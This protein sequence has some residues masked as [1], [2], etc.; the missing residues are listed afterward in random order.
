MREPSAVR[1]LA[2]AI[3]SVPVGLQLSVLYTLL[4]AATLALLGSV[5]YARVDDFLVRDQVDRLQ[6][7]AQPLLT[8]TDF[9][10]R[11]ERGRGPRNEGP[12]PGPLG[13]TPSSRAEFA[14]LSLVRGLS[15]PD[16]TVAL[17]DAEGEVITSTLSVGGVDP[18]PLPA[19]PAGWMMAASSAS[20]PGEGAHWMVDLE[21]RR[22]LVLVQ[23]VTLPEFGGLSGERFYLEQ[24]A[25][26]AAADSLLDQ[27]RLYVLVG[28]L[29]GTLIGVLAGLG[30][31]R[32]V[33]RPL[34]R[35]VSTAE[36]ISGGDLGRR[37]RLPLGRNE[38]ARLGRAFDHMVDRLASTLDAQ[39]RFVADASHELRTPLTSLEGLSEM[40]MMG[41][42]RGDT[43]V[44]QRTLRS[45]HG[46]LR[47]MSRLVNDLLTLSRLDSTA[48]V[49]PVRV[50]AGKL[51]AEVA[52]Q[53]EPVAV[54]QQ[55]R[56][57]VNGNGPAI[58]NGE[59]DK[60]RQVVL[61]LVDNA[62]RYTPSGGEVRLASGSDPAA[63]EVRIEVQDT[64]P[65]IPLAD[66]PHI[67]DRFYRGDPSRTR[68]TGNS[69][70]GLAIARAIV[71]AH[72]GAIRVESPPGQGAR[73][74]VV[75]PM[76]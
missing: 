63:G 55:V 52:A 40:L 15:G 74:T 50:D 42:D 57:V 34:D 33:L 68:A 64:G 29:A 58:V 31:T 20:A 23:P 5:L 54:A 66:L 19:L 18:R 45:M 1:R 6:R 22:H 26:L 37:L 10:G 14:A 56:L 53:M 2:S 48:T 41:A 4:F 46:E 61:N 3:W 59:P 25:S 8:R 24:V 76:K 11:P 32:A 36:A 21:G 51:L 75:L 72:G 38:V 27:L 44:V 9:F 12:G 60:L 62:V 69:G 71:R 73:F 39:R 17:L 35:M 67:F 13:S 7:S 47:R 30:L 28:I 70:L 43:H 16:V 49:S 65:G